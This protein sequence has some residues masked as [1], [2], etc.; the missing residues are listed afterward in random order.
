MNSTKYYPPWGDIS[1]GR[2]PKDI[3]SR[4]VI[5]RLI[6]RAEGLFIKYYNETLLNPVYIEAISCLTTSF[7]FPANSNSNEHPA[8]AGY[9]SNGMIL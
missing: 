1:R 2:S 6:S 3:S 7:W 5:F 9:T 8:A 4:W